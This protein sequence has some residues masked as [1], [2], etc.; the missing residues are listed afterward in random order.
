ML[1]L[2][3]HAQAEELAQQL[4]SWKPGVVIA[5]WTGL[6]TQAW[7]N[8]KTHPRPDQQQHPH[9]HRLQHLFVRGRRRSPG[10]R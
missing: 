5:P 8:L 4:T 7:T 10:G 1:P 9:P 2:Q 3:G 6:F